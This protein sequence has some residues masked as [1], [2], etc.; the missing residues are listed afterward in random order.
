MHNTDPSEDGM[1][2]MTPEEIATHTLASEMAGAVALNAA[3][4]EGA[5]ARKVYAEAYT[6]RRNELEHIAGFKA[7]FADDRLKSDEENT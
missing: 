6:V 5:D 3:G 7:P 2:M 4:E 1:V